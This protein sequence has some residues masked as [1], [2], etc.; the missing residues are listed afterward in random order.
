MNHI[1]AHK[2]LYT[3]FLLIVRIWS[4]KTLKLNKA[5]FFLLNR[6][7]INPWSLQEMDRRNIKE[8][9]L[10]VWSNEV[11]RIRLSSFEKLRQVTPLL[12]ARSNLRTHSPL[13]TFHTF[14]TD[15]N[16]RFCD[17]QSFTLNV[18][19]MRRRLLLRQTHLYLAVL[20]SWCQQVRVVAEG[21]SEH[22]VIHHHE[23]VLGL[24]LHVLQEIKH[25][26]THNESFSGGTEGPA[27]TAGMLIPAARHDWALN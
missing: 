15:T 9:H 11:L 3:L 20:S 4:D 8:S 14:A 23:A 16:T 12:W 1:F 17:V 6:F 25:A 7:N 2:D 10:R 27:C 21:Q 13:W 26:H 19:G 24:V 22:G 5:P 18:P